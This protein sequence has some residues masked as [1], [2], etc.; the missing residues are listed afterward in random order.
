MKEINDKLN[1]LRIRLRTSPIAENLK[2]VKANFFDAI[3]SKLGYITGYE[4]SGLKTLTREVEFDA[5][6]IEGTAIVLNDKVVPGTSTQNPSVSLRTNTFDD[7]WIGEVHRNCN[8]SWSTS[9]SSKR[10]TSAG[11][12]VLKRSVKEDYMDRVVF[13]GSPEAYEE[14]LNHVGGSPNAASRIKP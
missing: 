2:T 9:S 14:V 13:N 5:Q 6:S 7:G 3:R 10:A 8:P 12:T 11:Q 1:Q 4:Q